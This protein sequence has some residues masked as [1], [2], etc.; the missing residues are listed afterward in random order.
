M[1]EQITFGTYRLPV[2]VAGKMVRIAYDNGVRSF[3]TA[4]L[5]GN[6]CVFSDLDSIYLTTKI[7]RKSIINSTYDSNS[8]KTSLKSSFEKCTPDCVLLHSPEEGYVEAWKQLESLKEEFGINTGVSNFSILNLKALKSKPSINQIEITPFNQCRELVE[9]CER[10]DIKVSAHS[11]LT[12]G[13]KFK[14]LEKFP[15]LPSQL[16]LGWSLEKKYN[17]IFRTSSEEHLLE[18]LQVLKEENRKQLILKNLDSLE[19][20]F[21]THPQYILSPIR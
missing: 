12:K 7:H 15:G 14:S 13:E 19:E 5:Y 2:N 1:N 21:Q 10:E 20:R 3:D 18:N 16:L 8:I 6:E 4:Q 11:S 17:P 9:Y